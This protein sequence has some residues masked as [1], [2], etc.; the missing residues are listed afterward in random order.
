MKLGE[1][2]RILNG[3]LDGNPDIDITGI[4]EINRAGKGDITF[5]TGGKYLRE[6][7]KSDASAVILKEGL[8]IEASDVTMPY[9]SVENPHLSMVSLVELF[10]ERQYIHP[11]KG[12]DFRSVIKTGKIG[13]DVTIYPFVC[14]EEDVDIGDRTV[15]YPFT[16]VGRKSKIGAGSVIY[17][18]VNIYHNVIIGKNVII[19]SGAVIGSDGFGFVKDKD[20]NQRKVP[21]VGNVIIEDDVEIGANVCIDRATLGSTVIKRGVKIDNLVQIAHNVTVGNN[22]VI[23]GQTGISGSCNI[24]ANVMMGGQV[25]VTDHADIGD[26][27]VLAAKSGVTGDLKSG[28]Y[29]GFPA[30]EHNLWKRI[31]VVITKL[32]DLIKRVRELEKKINQ[33]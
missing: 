15:I 7:K 23:A 22:T 1:I 20:G 16:F 9:I 29:S 8:N 11:A 12:I 18:N 4:A 31:Q 25:G 6:L 26:G 2:A 3:K 13:K 21:Q 27:V 19:H 17:S 5:V 24:G 14:V 28:I 33:K 10:Y 32:P 30:I